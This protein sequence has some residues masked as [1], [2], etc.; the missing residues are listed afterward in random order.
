METVTLTPTERAVLRA[1]GQEAPLA[2]HYCKP[3]WAM[4]KDPQQAASFLAGSLEVGLRQAGNL[5]ASE[6]AGKLRSFLLAR[7]GKATS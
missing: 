7:A 6:V 2:L 4:M 5:D 1:T 3:C